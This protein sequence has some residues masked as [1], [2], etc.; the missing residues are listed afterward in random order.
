MR[1]RSVRGIA[2]ALLG[3]TVAASLFP[4]GAAQAAEPRSSRVC[5]S[6]HGEIKK[7]WEKSS[8]AGSWTNPVFQAFLADAKAALGEGAQ[9]GCISCHAPL[10]A[11]TGD[12]KVTDPVNQVGI[13]CNFCHS[14]SAVV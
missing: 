1:P 14:V 8:M 9:A 2:G 3:V 7:Q 12:V 6:C 4:R 13:T 11:V 5:S 10:A